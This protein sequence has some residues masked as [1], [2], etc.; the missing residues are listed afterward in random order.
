MDITE[1]YYKQWL[2]WN[3]K[4]L[5]T[6]ADGHSKYIELLEDA[7]LMRL[8]KFLNRNGRADKI[9]D[10]PYM[11]R[12]EIKSRNMIICSDFHVSY[13]PKT[14]PKLKSETLNNKETALQLIR[15]TRRN[16]YF[17]K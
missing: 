17:G 7:H 14:K 16:R 3:S 12:E 4:G 15:R 2:V 1:Y 11:I 5:W 6:T 9:S 8:P 13:K 10:L